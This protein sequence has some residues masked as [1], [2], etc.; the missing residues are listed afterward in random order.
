MNDRVD[1]IK[2]SLMNSDG[3]ELDSK[4]LHDDFTTI[5]KTDLHDILEMF[6]DIKGTLEEM[7][8]DAHAWEEVLQHGNV[9]AF[10]KEYELTSRIVNKYG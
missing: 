5:E 10:N 6:I 1:H 2:M 7:K 8:N 4:I 3:E 9:D